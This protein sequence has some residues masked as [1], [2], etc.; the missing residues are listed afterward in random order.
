MQ[1]QHARLHS[2]GG[3]ADREKRGLFDI[4]ATLPRRNCPVFIAGFATFS[5]ARVCCFATTGRAGIEAMTDC[6]LTSTANPVSSIA[7]MRSTWVSLTPA[8][9]IS[10]TDEMP[11]ADIATADQ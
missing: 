3:S 7:V 6:P 5:S 8:K 11:Y 4:A 1:S 9:S 2:T 10:V